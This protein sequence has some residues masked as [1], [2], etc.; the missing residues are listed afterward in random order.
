M[1]KLKTAQEW[2]EKLNP[3]YSECEVCWTGHGLC[4]EHR[5]AAIRAIR[6]NALEAVR[7]FK[8][9]GLEAEECYPE[10]LDF[11]DAEIAKL[12]AKEAQ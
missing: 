3:F 5:L 1:T 2:D 10:L 11:I 9:E 8:G 4:W 6:L 12:N 7:D